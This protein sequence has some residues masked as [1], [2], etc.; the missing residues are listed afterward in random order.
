MGKGEVLTEERERGRGREDG[1]TNSCIYI[2]IDA[3]EL[4]HLFTYPPTHLPPSLSPSLPLSLL[5]TD[6]LRIALC[7]RER[8]FIHRPDAGSASWTMSGWAHGHARASQW[9][10]VRIIRQGNSS[11]RGN[12]LHAG[13]GHMAHTPVELHV[14]YH[15]HPWT[16]RDFPFSMELCSF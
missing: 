1:N 11:S 6:F 9:L 3:D 15:T 7:R 14:T 8:E 12:F 4:T 10:R 16:G 2:Y 5:P 13:S